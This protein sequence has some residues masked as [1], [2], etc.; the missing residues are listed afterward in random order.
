MHLI[1]PLLPHSSVVAP[2]AETEDIGGGYRVDRPLLLLIDVLVTVANG[3]EPEVFVE[4]VALARRFSF[5]LLLRVTIPPP[6]RLDNV[7]VEVG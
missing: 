5:L 1:S 4:N 6:D 2:A 7:I 3:V